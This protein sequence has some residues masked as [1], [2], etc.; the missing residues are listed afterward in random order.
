MSRIRIESTPYK[1]KRGEF[2]RH[3]VM[4]DD[5]IMMSNDD[6]ELKELE[7]AAETARGDCLIIGLGLGLLP[8]E[9]RQKKGV[10][11]VDVVEIAQG[12]IELVGS[13]FVNTNVA[14]Y[15]ADGR[16]WVH[17]DG[18][19]YDWIYADWWLEPTYPVYLEW[20]EFCKHAKNHLMKDNAVID[21]WKNDWFKKGHFW[22]E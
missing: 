15:H 17:P 10:E 13:N 18:K 3:L 9:I 1:N 8:Q 4:E 14:V 11:S 19:R 21:C 7:A 5:K 12:V 20:V 22:Q 6:I 16:K 2:V